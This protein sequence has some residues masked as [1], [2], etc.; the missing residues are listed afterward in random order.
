MT[1][2]TINICDICEKKIAIEPCNICGKDVCV[3]CNQ[4]ISV[5]FDSSFIYNENDMR[6]FDI[7]VCQKCEITFFNV[8]S[9]E[10]TIC[11]EVF[12]NKPELKKEIIET[13]KNIIMLHKISGDDVEKEI[14]DEEIIKD[15]IKKPF[16][17]IPSIYKENPS[18]YYWNKDVKTTKKTY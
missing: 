3:D 1:E 18:P 6:L 11:E 15:F 5:G 8:C 12:K 16:K 4:K 7:I 2:K 9:R 17:K 10:N 13:I 14:K